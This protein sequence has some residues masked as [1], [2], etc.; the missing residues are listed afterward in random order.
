MFDDEGGVEIDALADR[1]RGEHHRLYGFVPEAPIEIVNARIEARGP[2]S[3]N[4]TGTPGGHSR[5]RQQCHGPPPSRSTSRGLGHKQGCTSVT[6]SGRGDVVEGPAIIVQTD[7]TTFV[8]SGHVA[9]TD[10]WL[11]LLIAPEGQR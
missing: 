5:R 6:C 10:A 1:F 2:G 8:H 3:A 4:R 7:T 9:A 11:N